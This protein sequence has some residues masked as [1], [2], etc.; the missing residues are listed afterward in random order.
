MSA[1]DRKIMYRCN[2]CGKV[3]EI[4]DLPVDLEADSLVTEKSLEGVLC[5]ACKKQ[6]EKAEVWVEINRESRQEFNRFR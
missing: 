6:L 5:S 3:E 4:V 2:Q 1:Q